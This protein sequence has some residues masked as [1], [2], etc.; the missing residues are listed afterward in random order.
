[1]TAAVVCT[2]TVVS[3]AV[4][5]LAVLVT[6]VVALDVGVIAEI[7]C[8]KCLDCRVTRAADTAIELDACLCKSHLCATANAS[9][10]KYVSA[11]DLQKPS[12]R[13]VSL[14]IGIDHLR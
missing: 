2:A 7:I 3:A 10:D 5:A 1:M 11:D 9:A 8:K 14:T 13:S 12:K 6:V 4:T